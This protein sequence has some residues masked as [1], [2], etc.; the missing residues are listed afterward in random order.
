MLGNLNPLN[1]PRKT[2]KDWDHPYF[3]DWPSITSTTQVPLLGYTFVG[4]PVSPVSAGSLCHDWNRWPNSRKG[5]F[6]KG[7]HD[8]QEVRYLWRLFFCW[9]PFSILLRHL[10]RWW[11]RT[12]LHVFKL[13]PPTLGKIPMLTIKLFNWLG[14]QAPRRAS[15]SHVPCSKILQDAMMPR[16]WVIKVDGKMPRS[17]CP[18]VVGSPQGG[19]LMIVLS[20]RGEITSE[21]M[22]VCIYCLHVFAMSMCFL[23]KYIFM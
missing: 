22:I 15:L 11:F 19:V 23:Y 3:K 17:C 12:C 9:H 14:F 2:L 7:R 18:N 16:L 1:A 21:S 4:L 5:W 6:W 20:W 10:A 8:K 13:H